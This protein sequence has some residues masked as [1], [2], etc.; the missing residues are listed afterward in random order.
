MGVGVGG[1]WLIIQARKFRCCTKRGEKEWKEK[2]ASNLD[3]GKPDGHQIQATSFRDPD[4]DQ[5]TRAQ[6]L[7]TES[8][9]EDSSIWAKSLEWRIDGIN[10]EEHES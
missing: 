3:P 7:I 5:K 1:F 9:Q 2:Q 10:K 4:K 6:D 8:R